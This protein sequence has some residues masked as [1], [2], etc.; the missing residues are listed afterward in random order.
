MPCGSATVQSDTFS[1]HSGH[2]LTGRG[3]GAE[4]I[5]KPWVNAPSALVTETLRSSS[6]VGF[7]SRR[8]PGGLPGRCRPQH[9]VT[10]TGVT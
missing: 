6:V 10:K 7:S 2:S 8:R 5:T 3:A 1:L 4:F 9:C